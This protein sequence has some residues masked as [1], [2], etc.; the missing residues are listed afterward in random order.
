LIQAVQLD[1][2]LQLFFDPLACFGALEL[3]E[4][5]SYSRFVLFGFF[6]L[7]DLFYAFYEYLLK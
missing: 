7:L 2:L 5:I 3:L 1:P 6:F 4:P